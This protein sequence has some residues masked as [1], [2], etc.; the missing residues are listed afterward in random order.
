MLSR[1]TVLIG[2]LAFTCAA[3]SSK[4]STPWRLE[5]ETSGGMTG[6][7][8]GNLVLESDGTISVTTMTQKTC[9]YQATAEEMQS[10]EALL[11]A[12]HPEKWGTYFPQN[13]CCDRIEYKLTYGKFSG[14]W[15][16]AGPPMPRDLAK[17]SD[18]LGELRRK[19]DEQ[20]RQP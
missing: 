9:S 10:I 20:C 1:T 13:K 4:V 2:M 8:L 16:D 11:A 17:L 19:Y 3:S 6:R 7:G 18:A 15:I 5:L 14:E 12:S